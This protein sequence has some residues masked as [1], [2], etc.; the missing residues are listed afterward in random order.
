[1][2][3]L[4]TLA[5]EQLGDAG[6]RRDEDADPGAT[7]R[8]DDMHKAR[9]VVAR[10]QR[11]LRRRGDMERG[12]REQL[13]QIGA[14]GMGDLIACA[15]SDTG[16]LKV[17]LGELMDRIDAM[18][19][20]SRGSSAARLGGGESDARVL[21]INRTPLNVRRRDFKAAADLMHESGWEG[22]PLTGPRTTLLVLSFIA[23]HTARWS[24]ATP[25]SCR[26]G[27]CRRTMLACRT[28]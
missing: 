4:L 11:S 10:V 23:E 9:V 18:W 13:L 8:S 19:R 12:L 26:T 27:V 6:T 21:A 24:N 22:W 20:A 17:S 15:F 7:P 14:D 2:Q 25:D 3:S 16:S 28:T 5:R 1:M